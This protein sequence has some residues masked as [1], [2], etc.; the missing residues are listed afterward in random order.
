MKKLQQKRKNENVENG[1]KELK[2]NNDFTTF[3]KNFITA[4]ERELE[5][6]ICLEVASVPTVTSF[7]EVAARRLSRFAQCAM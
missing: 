3:L 4:K 5:C 1:G 6:P 2:P 7:V